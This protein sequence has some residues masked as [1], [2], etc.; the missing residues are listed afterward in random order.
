MRRATA[1]ALVFA[2]VLLGARALPLHAA[3]NPQNRPAMEK[4]FHHADLWVREH[5]ERVSELSSSAKAAAASELSRMGVRED[6]GFYDSRVGRF[7]S[8]VLSEPLIPG[9]GKGNTL[10]WEGLANPSESAIRERTWSAVSAFLARHQPELRLDA[11]E[12]GVPRITVHEKGQLVYVYVPRIVGGVT[13]RNS[14]IGITINHGNLVLLGLQNWGQMSTSLAPSVSSNQ[15]RAV[16]VDHAAPYSATFGKAAY[17]E[18]I[19]VSP[20]DVTLSYRLAW[21]VRMR[22][23]NDVGNWEALVDAHSGELLSFEDKNDYA[24]RQIFGGVYPVSNDGRVPDGVEQIGWPMPYVDIHSGPNVSFTDQGG[25]IGCIVGSISSSLSGR[26]LK[27]SDQCGAIN[28]TSAS[29]NIDLGS[30]PSAAATDCTTPG[31]GHSAGDTKSSRTGYFELN[32]LIQRAKGW[33]PN[34]TWLDQQLTANMNITDTCNAF[35]DGVSVNFFKSGGGCRNTGEQAAIF[36]HEWGHG[37]DNNDTNPNISSP[38]EAVADISALTRLDE[39]CIGRGFSISQVCGGY[40]DACDGTAATGCTGVRDVDFMNHRCNLPHT[41]TWILSGFTPGQC[42]GGATACPLLGQLGPCAHET[43]CEGYVGAETFWDMAKRDFT[44][45]PYNYD[46]NTALEI[47]TRLYLLGSQNLTNWYTCS[48]GGGCGATGGYLLVLAADDDNG[49]L[50]DGTPHMVG[51]R[52]AFARHQIHCATPAPL[53]SG[54]AGGPT[55]AA[56]VIATALDKG[57]AL[58]WAAVTGAASYD[59]YRTDG[60]FA[61]DFGKIKVGNTTELTF[62]ENG[63]QN[64]RT[65]YYSVIAVGANTACYAPMS[66]CATVVPTAGP[67]LAVN[68]GSTLTLNSGDGDDF[69][70]NCESATLTFSVANTGTGAVTNVQLVGVTPLTHPLTTIDTTLPAPISASL[71]ECDSA[72]GS[73]DFTPHGLAFDETTQFLVEVSGDG[74]TGTRTMIVSIPH[75]E[76]DAAPVATRTYSFETDLQGWNVTSG[77][78]T[79]KAPGANGTG[80]HLSSS[81]NI[82]NECDVI[83]SPAIRLTGTSTLSLYDKYVTESPVPIP[84]DRANVGVR[85]IAAGTRTTVVPT[86]GRLYD[87]PQPTANGVCVTAG[88]GGWAGTNATFAQSTWNSGALNPGGAFTGKMVNIEVGYG[89]DEALSL[90][91]LDFDEVTL[92]NFEELAPDAQSDSCVTIINIAPESLTVDAGGN[93]VLDPNESVI[94]S[95][96]WGNLGN[97]TITLTGSAGSFTGP[98]NGAGVTYSIPDPSADYGSILVGQTAQCTNCYSLN[99]ATTIRPLQHWDATFF[100]TMAPIGPPLGGGGPPAKMWTLHVGNSF[101]DVDPNIGSDPFYPFIETILHK[102]VTSGCGDGSTYC[103]LQNVLRQEMAVFLL[104][105]FLGS[106]YAPPN[107]TGLFQDVPCPPTP[108]F[109]F[110]NF[111]EDLSTRGITS[112]C[113]VGPPALF[114]PDQNVTRAQM[115][116]FLLKTLLGGAYTPPVCTSLFQDVPCPPTPQFPFSNFIEDLSTRG[117]TSGCQVGP[118]A[119]Y[120]PDNPVTRQ[121]MAVFL[122][123]TFGLVLYGL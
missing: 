58:A 89:T 30:G 44:A 64:G 118:P 78:Y 121:E 13:V 6:L 95:P 52:S 86:S 39:S 65:Y 56:T 12:F 92:T 11:S 76:T 53:D 107:C 94:V 84:Y 21:V 25:N 62:T 106:G 68:P 51:I 72:E 117:I 113:Q 7:S 66:D 70:D 15:A 8:L 28:E 88:Q 79:R 29:G 111:I 24:Q 93:H 40:G 57:A 23:A 105:G 43:H 16:A 110:S 60:V 31:A 36:D 27:I 80:F 10:H 108:Q 48:V 115:A 82:N 99:L 63:L 38:G 77:I 54:C 112:G 26:F 55:E 18:L 97:T 47:T 45:A 34:N 59:V 102:G 74:L 90:A 116:A 104:K 101:S 123:L 75:V 41:I 46:V 73:F 87:L 32:Q 83:D 69:L 91:G 1:R 33:L 100:E 96:T 71:A 9:T 85:D 98:G 3:V 20:G 122:S 42:S 22:L 61:C 103:P 114:C 49:N 67:N 81:E 119:L 4:T 2:C 120:C 17:L 109:P 50:V 19:P 35:W 5:Q 37:L 14:S